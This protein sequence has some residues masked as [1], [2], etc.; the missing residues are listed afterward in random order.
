MRL[1]LEAGS[2]EIGIKKSAGEWRFG[3][4]PH[5]ENGVSEIP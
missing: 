2:H 5:H 1:Y 4:Y 3:T